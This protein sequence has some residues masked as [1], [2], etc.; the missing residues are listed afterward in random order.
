MLHDPPVLLL[1]EPTSAMDPQSAKLVRE[2][3]L[4]LR[5]K[6]RS[7]VLCTHNLHEAEMLADRIA[8]IRRGEIII[9]GTAA[10][11]KQDLLGAPTYELRFAGSL[12]G[13][14]AVVGDL[15]PITDK[16]ENWMRYRT[17]RPCELNPVL[18]DRLSAAKIK[19]MTLSEAPH[20]LEEVYLQ[21]V[22]RPSGQ[23]EASVVLGERG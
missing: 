13:A 10:Q 2:S 16:G 21:V 12:D 19:V 15:V 9:Q 5:S 17:D 14:A 20:S 22:G 8:I 3:I 11:L 7:I 4:S 18:L 23:R 6:E 1:D